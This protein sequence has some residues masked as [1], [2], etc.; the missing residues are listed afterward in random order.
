[1]EMND[2]NELED[3]EDRY[4]IVIKNLDNFFIQV[5]SY[6]CRKGLLC[7]FLEE[8]TNLLLSSFLIF[9]VVFDLTWSENLSLL[10]CKDTEF[11]LLIL[12]IKLLF[13]LITS[14]FGTKILQ[15]SDL[16]LLK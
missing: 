6:Y 13:S 14:F 12:F 9:F 8:V 3:E 1:M 5:Y 15:S 7:I 16:Y 2:Y 4:H 11:E 10:I